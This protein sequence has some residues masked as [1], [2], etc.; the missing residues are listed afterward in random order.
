MVEHSASDGKAVGSS[1]AWCFM[2]NF[3]KNKDFVRTLFVVIFFGF[4]LWY[5]FWPMEDN[6][7][8][9]EKLENTIEDN[10]VENTHLETESV[11]SSMCHLYNDFFGWDRGLIV[12]TYNEFTSIDL[13]WIAEIISDVLYCIFGGAILTS[14]FVLRRRMR[15]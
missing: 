15:I 13:S 6:L 14:L 11:W 12:D 8:A 10:I 5:L 9:I 7:D 4:P 3:F 1:P 2:V